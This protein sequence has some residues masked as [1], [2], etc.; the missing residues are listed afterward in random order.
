MPL[1][2]VIIPVHNRPLPL[3]Q[4]IDSV[5]GQTF[6]D[7]E[8][9]VVDD[10]STD[11]TRRAAEMYGKRIL[12]VRQDHRGVSAARNAGIKQSSAPWIAFLD[13]DDRWLPQKLARHA[14]YIR[15]HPGVRIHQTDE[16]WIRKGRRVNPKLR[17]LK[18]DGYLFI[19]SLDLCLISP[20]AV[21]MSR[22][23]FNRYGLFDEFLPACEDYDLWLRVTRYEWVG[24]IPEKLVVRHGGHPDQLSVRH[25]GM[26]RFRV[27]SILHLLATYGDS[28]KPEYRDRA[29]AAAVR[30]A[31]IL[32]DGAM[33]RKN[34]EFAGN[35]RYIIN[36]LNENRF[37][38]EK[39][40]F[41]IED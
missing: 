9:I 25:W 24:R 8:L 30:K 12:Y 28:L 27:Y 1:F 15:E 41:L 21:V 31:R 3:M 5:L 17:H 18:R 11:G 19:D 10:G 6:G 40:G 36:E 2:S 26:D 35:I 22:A 38:I 23:L 4:A 37:S 29:A 32:M 13:S 39:Y 7:F 33:K 14:C 34:Q 16:Q 20:S